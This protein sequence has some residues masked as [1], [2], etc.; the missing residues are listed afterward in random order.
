MSQMPLR[1]GAHARARE[2]PL[3]AHI[4][5]M[6]DSLPNPEGLTVAVAA[7]MLAET[8]HDVRNACWKHGFP[9]GRSV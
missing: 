3:G 9:A 4:L 7:R 6:L 1:A 8:Q 5:D 2:T